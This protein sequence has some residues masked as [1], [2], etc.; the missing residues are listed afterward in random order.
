MDNFDQGMFDNTDP[1][2]SSFDLPEGKYET[3]IS[4]CGVQSHPETGR[5]NGFFEFSISEPEYSNRKVW[6]NF[7]IEPK[8]TTEKQIGNAKKAI[9]F[10]KKAFV[11][12]GFPNDVTGWSSWNAINSKMQVM[13]NVPAEIYVKANPPHPANIYINGRVSDASPTGVE[14]GLPNT[15]PGLDDEEAIPF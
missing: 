8:D 12:L 1:A 9:A 5:H 7:Y 15:A 3:V 4:E 2:E 13:K 6:K 14:T 11:D 10:L